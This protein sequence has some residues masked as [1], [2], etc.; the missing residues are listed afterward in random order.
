MA[1]RFRQAKGMKVHVVEA[2]SGEKFGQQTMDGMYYMRAMVAFCFENYGEK[3]ASEY[4]S[5]Y[6]AKYA[7]EHGIPIIP[8]K[9]YAGSWPPT[10]DH[11]DSVGGDAQNAFVFKEDLVYCQLLP[12]DFSPERCAD[13][14]IKSFANIIGAR[15]LPPKPSRENKPTSSPAA[16]E[17]IALKLPSAPSSV[18]MP[19]ARFAPAVD[20]KDGHERIGVL[21]SGRFDGGPKEKAL[22]D[23]V[24]CLQARHAHPP[25]ALPA[26]AWQL[27]KRVSGALSAHPLLA[28]G[29]F[30]AQKIYGARFNTARSPACRAR[31]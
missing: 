24:A 11:G 1:V 18:C 16:A 4:S 5:F 9:L 12:A 25:L 28:F 15:Y 22:R 6:E 7:N 27:L 2:V 30:Y 29:L 8:L 13:E 14:I 10:P 21:A 20:P 26:C 17:E 19:T 3:T 23:T 31:A